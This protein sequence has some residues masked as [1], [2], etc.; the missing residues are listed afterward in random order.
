MQ[1]LDQATQHTMFD[2]YSEQ[3]EDAA[4]ADGM[5]SL[6]LAKQLMQ[7]HS[8]SL[9]AMEQDGYKGHHLDA[10]ALLEWLGY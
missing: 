10:F 9:Y 7:D 8:T 6:I 2:T 1:I 3:V 4:D 5:L